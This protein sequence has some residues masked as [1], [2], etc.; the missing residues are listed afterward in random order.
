MR[1]VVYPWLLSLLVA[2]A[3]CAADM[4][5]PGGAC[6]NDTEC[7]AG[8]QCYAQKV[9]VVTAVQDTPVIL[10]LTPPPKSG[11][12]VESFHVTLR[13][14]TQAVPLPPL[15]LGQ[16][17][18]IHGTVTQAG[19]PLSGSIPGS[20]S[21]TAQ[22]PV[23]GNDLQFSATSLIAP[24]AFAGAKQPA[25]FELRVQPGHTYDLAFWPE[26]PKIPPHYTSITVGGSIAEWKIELPAQEHLLRIGGRLVAGP[27]ALAGL[28]VSL[29][30]PQG[31]LC[32]TKVI[33]ND[34]GS[35]ELH[36]DPSVAHGRLHF[37]PVDAQSPLP[38]GR[39]ESKIT[40]PKSASAPLDLG[41]LDVGA[42]PPAQPMEI[43]AVGIGGE[44][45]AGALVRVQ[46]PLST[47]KDAA[48]GSKTPGQKEEGT[49]GEKGE[50]G[51]TTKLTGLYLETYGYAD[52][53]GIFA[54][55]LPPGPASISVVTAPKSA[56]GKGKW[57]GEMK[58]LAAGGVLT[59]PCPK[60][61]LMHG[62]VEDY[63]DQ[64]VSGAKVFLR[65][66]EDTAKAGSGELGGDEALE[67]HDDG[68]GKFSVLV[69]PGTYAVWVQP[70]AGS[71]LARVLAKIVEVATGKPA[72]CELR[73]PPPMVLVGSVL[74]AHGPLAG[75]LI[76]VLAAKVSVP[77][78][79]GS[80]A[81]EPRATLASAPGVL[82]DSHLLATTTSGGNGA[83]EVLLAPGQVAQ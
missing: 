83:F 14:A 25:G 16:P 20:L 12:L 8:L 81:N 5:G 51:A 48:Q 29:E 24:K 63:V 21:A 43:R 31:R 54:T 32:S 15:W 40:L 4:A 58:G 45:M 55:E 1:A 73:L 50:K 80:A 36:V 77:G 78:K 72:L 2:L 7:T 52:K 9:C 22:S 3:G 33:T 62:T 53:S 68:G 27:V 34:S 44:L 79:T 30:D 66:L 39:S 64:P 19:N 18:V 37:E 11:L 41:A 76:D 71:G 70:P 56:F 38:H 6:T 10:R 26:S 59:V 28:R 23:A 13:G 65:R 74:T 46:R 67:A 42:L 82:L 47:S 69:D 75:V 35:F 17:A 60:R 49:D 57:K 61:E